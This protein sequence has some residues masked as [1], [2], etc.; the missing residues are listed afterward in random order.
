MRASAGGFLNWVCDGNTNF[1]KGLDNSTGL[2]FDSELTNAISSV[3]GFPRLTDVSPQ[4]A[5]GTPADGQAAPETPVRQ[6]CT[7]DTTSG[8]NQITVTGAA[9]SR[10]TSST[11][12]GWSIATCLTAARSAAS[13]SP[14]P[15]SRRGTTVVSGAGTSHADPVEQRDRHRD[16]CRHGVRRRAGRHSGGQPADITSNTSQARALIL[17][18]TW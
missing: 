12:A 13:A 5:I 10:P 7:V 3:F 2:N 8:S 14:T 6:A 15:T 9:T 17:P 11:L 1:T 18:A 4:P 16:R